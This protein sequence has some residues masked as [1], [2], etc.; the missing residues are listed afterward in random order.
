[1]ELEYFRNPEVI[2]LVSFFASIFLPLRKDG[3]NVKMK[4]QRRALDG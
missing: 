4:T 2:I 3:K 1:M